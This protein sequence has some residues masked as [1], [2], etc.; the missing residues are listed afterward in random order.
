V[1][2]MIEENKTSAPKLLVVWMAVGSFAYFGVLL[3]LGLVALETAIIEGA[4]GESS[5]IDLGFSAGFYLPNIFGCI[6][7]GC[8]DEIH[9]RR[10]YLFNTPLGSLFKTGFGTGF[11]G[12]LTTFATW[13]VFSTS[14]FFEGYVAL[15]LFNMFV[16]LMVWNA[17][18]RIGFHLPHLANFPSHHPHP[19][20]PNP[21]KNEPKNYKISKKRDGDLV[22]I[23]NEGSAPK[24]TKVEMVSIKKRSHEIVDHIPDEKDVT[25]H[26]ILHQPKQPKDEQRGKETEKAGWGEGYSLESVERGFTGIFLALTIIFWSLALAL[27]NPDGA[28]CNFLFFSVSFSPLGAGLRWFI[29]RFNKSSTPGCHGPLCDVRTWN[30]PFYTFLANMLGCLDSS[31]VFNADSRGACADN[32]RLAAGSGLA[33]SLSTIST[34]ISESDKLALIHPWY[35]YRYQLTSLACAQA[36]NT[37]IFGIFYGV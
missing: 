3:R 37:V 22:E 6:F 16:G 12:S 27:A 36:L 14:H 2:G 8:L 20:T 5:M 32:I 24:I 1:V 4:A 17:S 25:Q 29:G 33:G 19:P 10:T 9:A 23:N 30:F 7:L 21:A 18:Y 26:Q 35:F 34:F 11:C 13:M 15:G 31:I 28:P